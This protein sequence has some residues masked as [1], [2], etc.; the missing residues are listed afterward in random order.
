[1]LLERT[2]LAIIARVSASQTNDS[3][4][5]TAFISFFRRRQL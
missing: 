1:M 4:D 2:I 5:A 3:A